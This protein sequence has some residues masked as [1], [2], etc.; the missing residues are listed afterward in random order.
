[1]IKITTEEYINRLYQ[2]FGDKVSVLGEYQGIN[3]PIKHRCRN[4]HEFCQSPF[5]M[6][7][8][9]QP[10]PICRSITDPRKLSKDEFKKR[11]YKAQGTKIRLLGVYEGLNS[12]AE[13][14]C[15]QGHR[16][17]TFSYRL[18]QK[19]MCPKCRK[20]NGSPRKLTHDCYLQRLD[21]ID[22]PLFPLEDYQTRFTNILHACPEGHVVS[23]CPDNT[24]SGK[25][26]HV[27]NK[28]R[29]KN[30]PLQITKAEYVKRLKKKKPHI[31]LIGD[32]Q[33]VRVL[34]LHRCL[35]HN[36][37]WKTLPYNLMGHQKGCPKCKG[38]AIS[39]ALRDAGGNYV[40][41]K[42]RHVEHG[43]K[44][45]LLQGYEPQALELIRSWG[46]RDEQILLRGQVPRFPY[47]FKG[48][49]HYYYPDFYIPSENRIVEVKSDYTFWN[50]YPRNRRK[51]KAVR[52]AGY[53]YSVLILDAQGNRIMIPRKWYEMPKVGV[54]WFK[55]HQLRVPEFLRLG[56]D[57]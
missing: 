31:I 27:C 38:A 45:V 8:S 24:L 18:R 42:F 10:C 7:P 30:R 17:I 36:H 19:R 56:G 37:E 54:K 14:R 49:S 12:K 22:S 26:C 41:Y 1:M 33:G 47:K 43:G 48:K 5:H 34:T 46:Y 39:E 9:V 2:K 28:L 44:L 16:F 4:G 3:T 52:K 32:Y 13:F 57:S 20:I 51:A 50:F 15:D 23:T 25:G 55:D 53:K 29:L 35:I 40:T 6:Y 11:L 21:V